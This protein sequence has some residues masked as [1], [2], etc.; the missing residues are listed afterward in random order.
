MLND[1]QQSI[2]LLRVYI[3]SADRYPLAQQTSS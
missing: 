1:D 3:H 2:M